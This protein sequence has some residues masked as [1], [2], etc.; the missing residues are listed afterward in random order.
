MKLSLCKKSFAMQCLSNHSGNPK[1]VYGETQARTEAVPGCAV[2]VCALSLNS[3]F[4]SFAEREI[5]CFFQFDL[6]VLL[7]VNR[8]FGT[9][10]SFWRVSCEALTCV[11]PLKVAGVFLS[12]SL[13][14]ESPRRQTTQASPADIKPFKSD[15]K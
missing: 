14:G 10:G 8:L 3:L 2:S 5:L 15:M 11:G 13:A 1:G 6:Y 9:N 12:G 7:A 4:C